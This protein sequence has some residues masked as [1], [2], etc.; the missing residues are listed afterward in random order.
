VA[1]VATRRRSLDQPDTAVPERRRQSISF[2]PIGKNVA[3]EMTE[4][5]L[6]TWEVP[7]DGRERWGTGIAISPR[8]DPDPKMYVRFYEW[9]LFGAV[10]EGLH[11]QADKT[12]PMQAQCD[13]D[14]ATVTYPA[15][16]V[17]LDATVVEEGVELRITATNSGTRDWPDLASIV[18][19]FNP[20]RTQ[21][22]EPTTE[23]F[24]DP[25]QRHTYYYGRTGFEPLT[26]RDV[27]WMADCRD[28]IEE[29]RP[30]D[31]FP[32]DRKWPTADRDATAPLV[33]RETPDGS[34]AT[35]IAWERSISA[36]GNNPWNC[37][38][39]SAKLG[40][41]APGDTTRT[42]GKLYLQS[43]DKMAI[44]EQYEA[45]FD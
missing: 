33:V 27:H 28:R 2:I 35:G 40:P 14:Q 42:R 9:N 43:T 15:H 3:T 34:W 23:R 11:S 18:P 19:C 6:E 24:A 45:D 39:L 26:G 32:W 36:Q 16:D 10:R 29:R 37:L 44:R 21:D 22:G 17:T 25:E 1:S 38:H 20:G 4:L 31:G 7:G 30:P 5:V 12:Q 8:Y 41:V 13:G